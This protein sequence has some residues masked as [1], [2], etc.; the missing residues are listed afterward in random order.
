MPYP[1]STPRG[2]KKVGKTLIFA[3]LGKRDCPTDAVEDYCR[4]LGEVFQ[5]H[6]TGYT[7]ARFE[8][9]KRGWPGA[10]SDLWRKSADWKGDWALVQYTALMWSRRGFPML[11]LPALWALKIRGVRTALVFHDS[12]PF[13]GGRYVDKVR[14]ACQRSVMRWAY[15]LS[16][17]TI[18]TLPVAQVGWLP[19]HHAKAHFIPVCATLPVVNTPDRSPRNGHKAKVISVLGITDKGDISKEVADITLAAKRAAEHLPR[20]RLVTV[21]RGSARAEAEFRRALAGSAVEYRALGVLPAEEVSQVLANSN[22]SLFVRG[23]ISTQRSS[24]V[25]S[26]ANGVPLVAYAD[27]CLPALAE[28]GVIG[29]PYPDG[30]E[31]AAATM[32]VLT[33]S[34]LW[35][36]LHERSRR[37][38]EKYFAWEVVAG[39][40]LEVLR[41]A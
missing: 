23:R 13:G 4:L 36:D 1:W 30:D 8:W 27:P 24:A 40:F 33:D 2:R 38:H 6:G 37:A 17:A 20:V 16:D 11:F 10:L 34:D 9:D 28:A 29:V 14:R 41:R 5:E 18:V 35:L 19:S 21:G 32:R 3:V 7:L 31:L 22:V 15:R 25:A 39:S 26:I 12:T